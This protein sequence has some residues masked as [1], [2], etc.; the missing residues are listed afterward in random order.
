MNIERSGS[1]YIYDNVLKNKI[2]RLFHG[3]IE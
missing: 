3:G 1:I 2:L